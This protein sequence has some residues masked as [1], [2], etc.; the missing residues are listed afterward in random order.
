MLNPSHYMDMSPFTPLVPPVIK[1]SS[2][3]VT[4]HLGQD[5]VLPCEVEGDASPTVIW[6]KDGFPLSQDNNKYVHLMIHLAFV[7][8]YLIIISPF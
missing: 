5:A 3:V 7:P 2:S 6:R 4:A 1:E 8:L